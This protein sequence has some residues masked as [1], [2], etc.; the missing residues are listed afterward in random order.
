[1]QKEKEIQMFQNKKPE[2][3]GNCNFFSENESKGCN[4]ID[5]YEKISPLKKIQLTVDFFHF[6]WGSWTIKL[7]FWGLAIVFIGAIFNFYFSEKAPFPLE[8]FGALQIWVGFILGIVATLFSIISMYLSFYN[9]E[10]QKDSE[11]ESREF[12]KSIKKEI[13]SEVKIEVSNRLDIISEEMKNRFGS[14]EEMVKDTQQG[15][16]EFRKTDMTKNE[17][18]N[19]FFGKIKLG[20]E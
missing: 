8:V 1:M 18:I 3:L 6:K 12:L 9:L 17:A 20:K 5:S 4:I 10:L 16:Q 2:N 14:L 19:D 7:V 15:I 13:V 11:K